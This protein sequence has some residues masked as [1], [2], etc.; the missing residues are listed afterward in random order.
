MTKAYEEVVGFI[1]AGTTPR[2]RPRARRNFSRQKIIGSPQ[3]N[4]A[5]LKDA[6]FDGVEP[7]STDKPVNFHTLQSSQQ[8]LSLQ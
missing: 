6:G 7:D 3:K 5:V 8:G 1:A 4:I 2:L